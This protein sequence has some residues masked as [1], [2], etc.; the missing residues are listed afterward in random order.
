MGSYFR[1]AGDVRGGRDLWLNLLQ[2]VSFEANC[3][4][5]IYGG[6]VGVERD[7][8]GGKPQN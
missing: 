1:L 4:D 7:V 2:P 8:S 3:V 6:T 5:S